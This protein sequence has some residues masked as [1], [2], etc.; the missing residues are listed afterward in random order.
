VVKNHRPRFEV[1]LLDD[2]K[3]GIMLV[4]LLNGLLSGL[5]STLGG[6]VSGVGGLLGGLF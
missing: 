6:V 1:G 4:T 5:T 3:G 2:L